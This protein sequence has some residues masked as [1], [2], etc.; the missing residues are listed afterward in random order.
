MGAKWLHGL[1]SSKAVFPHL[2]EL[3]W[4]KVTILKGDLEAVIIDQKC[5]GLLHIN[6]TQKILICTVT[7]LDFLDDLQN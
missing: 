7:L 2:R 4:R 5:S 6:C 3:P 1:N